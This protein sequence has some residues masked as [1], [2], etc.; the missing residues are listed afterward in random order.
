MTKEEA[1][2]M[3][4][5]VSLIDDSMYQYNPWY[6]VALNM[7]IE[8][9]KTEAISVEWIQQ[10]MEAIHTGDIFTDGLVRIHIEN[11]VDNW[12]KEQKTK[13]ETD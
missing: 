7:A 1:I 4:E 3:L 2:N 8:S 11:M 13:N 6:C 12:L 5:E 9:L 10:Y